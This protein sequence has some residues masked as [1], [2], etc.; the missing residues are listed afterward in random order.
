MSDHLYLDMSDLVLIKR[1]DRGEQWVSRALLERWQRDDPTP[2]K[3]IPLSWHP[4][5]APQDRVMLNPLT[6]PSPD[7]LLAPKKPSIP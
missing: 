6:T 5:G 4:E 7:G 2:P 1:D 3:P